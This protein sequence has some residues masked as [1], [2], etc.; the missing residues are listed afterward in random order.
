MVNNICDNVND[1]SLIEVIPKICCE[2]LCYCAN[3]IDDMELLTAYIKSQNKLDTKVVH[4]KFLCIENQT[5]TWNLG[6]L[7]L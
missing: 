4:N 6:L 1:L 2:Y 3:S 5:M 7:N